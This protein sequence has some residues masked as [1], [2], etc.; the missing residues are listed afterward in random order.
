MYKK[1]CTL[2]AL[3]SLFS[4]H[5]LAAP[6]QE[7]IGRLVFDIPSIDNF[8]WALNERY[9][10]PTLSGLSVG[11]SDWYYNQTRFN[12]TIPETKDFFKKRIINYQIDPESEIRGLEQEIKSY[13]LKIK[14]LKPVVA[15][16]KREQEVIGQQE[17]I[18]EQETINDAK[19][20]IKELE[21]KLLTIKRLSQYNIPTLAIQTPIR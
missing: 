16:K 15:E 11:L 19:S 12:V 18:P 14:A 8:E 10:S 3:S 6:S 20:E 21:K 7:C 17:E 5:L 4:L 2:F 1:A 9:G 13:Y